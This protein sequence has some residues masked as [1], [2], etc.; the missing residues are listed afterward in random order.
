MTE[1]FLRRG[2]VAELTGL[3]VSLLKRNAWLGLG[4]KFLKVG[5]AVIYRESDVL[6]WLNGHE[7]N[8][9][10]DGVSESCEASVDA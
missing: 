2:E 4:P 5:R 8:K 9:P 6:S 1:R 3:S 7:A 10:A